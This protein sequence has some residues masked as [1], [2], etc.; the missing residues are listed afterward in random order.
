MLREVRNKPLTRRILMG[1]A[2]SIHDP[3]VIATPFTIRLK[4]AMKRVM[5]TVRNDMKMK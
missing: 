3:L 4:I 5:E 1:L 2:N